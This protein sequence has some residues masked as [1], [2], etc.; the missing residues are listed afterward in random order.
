M[1][2]L[3]L[4]HYIYKQVSGYCKMDKLTD[5]NIDELKA[6]SY[7]IEKAVDAGHSTLDKFPDGHYDLEKFLYINFIERF[8]GSLKSIN[9]LLTKLA[10]DFLYETSIGL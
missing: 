9:L 2:E 10:A 7:I 4:H 3:L 5:A 6:L 1:C 8:T